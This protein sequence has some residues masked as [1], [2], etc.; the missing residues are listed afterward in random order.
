[1]RRGS[2]SGQQSLKG[3][4]GAALTIPAGATLHS[5]AWLGGVWASG[6]T[7]GSLDAW[8]ATLTVSP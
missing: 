1:L 7:A 3:I 4:R 8:S 2:S 5:G 6:E